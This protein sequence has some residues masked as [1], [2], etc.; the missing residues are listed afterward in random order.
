MLPPFETLRDGH[1]K[2]KHN[3][4]LYELGRIDD[5]Q[6]LLEAA[7]FLCRHRPPTKEG[8]TTIR[9]WRLNGHSKPASVPDLLHALCRAFDDYRSTHPDLTYEDAMAAILA[10]KETVEDVL[11]GGRVES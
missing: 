4:L 3:T 5:H 1:E 9:R 8:L 11:K 7:E 10:F 2:I 6:E